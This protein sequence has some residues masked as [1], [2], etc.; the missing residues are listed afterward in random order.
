[1]TASTLVLF[2]AGLAGLACSSRT[3]LDQGDALRAQHAVSTGGTVARE[4]TGG[5]APST[6]GIGSGG[7]AP[8]TGGIGSGGAGGT[9]VDDAAIRQALMTRWNEAV[10][11]VPNDMCCGLTF[12]WDE[13]DKFPHAT[14]KTGSAEAYSEF[15]RILLAFFESGDNFDFLARNGLF[16]LPLH[17]L[18]LPGTWT[19]EGLAGTLSAMR[20]VPEAAR[21]ALAQYAARIDELL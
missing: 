15:G 20:E 8:S 14:Y 13:F 12:D 19:F 16:Q 18:N 5:A 2:M 3:A 17:Y 6:G 10:A 4:S 7:T 1:M 21:A 9:A 11:I